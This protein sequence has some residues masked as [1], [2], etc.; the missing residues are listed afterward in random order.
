M[1]KSYKSESGR[2]RG[3]E[4]EVDLLGEGVKS[5]ARYDGTR[6][7]FWDAVRLVEEY[8]QD[9]WNPEEPPE[10]ISQ[11]CRDLQSL[12][13]LKIDKLIEEETDNRYKTFLETFASDKILRVFNARKS[14][15][16]V[17]YGTD[18]F[19][20]FPLDEYDKIIAALDLTRNREKYERGHKTTVFY[21]PD[22]VN[23]SQ[24]KTSEREELLHNVIDEIGNNIVEG[25][26]RKSLDRKWRAK[27]TPNQ[28][29]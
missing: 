12:I 9:G 8:Q 24:L 19:F 17:Q 2:Y 14:H 3:F 28:R 18:V 15:L 16:D 26:K 1:R 21:M 11:F 7:E 6:K 25:L 29:A 22:E 23:Y 10:N 4:L 27:F 5:P 20:E 13:Q